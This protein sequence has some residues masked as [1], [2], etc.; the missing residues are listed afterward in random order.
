MGNLGLALKMVLFYVY[1]LMQKIGEEGVE[2]ELKARIKR[3]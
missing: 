2:L 1:K 3:F